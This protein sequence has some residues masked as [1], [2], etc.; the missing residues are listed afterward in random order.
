MMK[1]GTWWTK[2][3]DERWIA[4]GRDIVGEFEMPPGL[5]QFLASKEAELGEKPPGDLEWGYMKDY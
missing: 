1:E 2:S 3:S 5:L 4:E